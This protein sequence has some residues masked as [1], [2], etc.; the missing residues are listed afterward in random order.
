VFTSTLL[1]CDGDSTLEV[2][3]CDGSH[4]RVLSADIE[5]GDVVSVGL[6]HLPE[7]L[8]GGRGVVDR[9]QGTKGINNKEN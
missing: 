4:L 9:V 5:D 6:K 8:V 2:Q 3:G 1:P 7:G